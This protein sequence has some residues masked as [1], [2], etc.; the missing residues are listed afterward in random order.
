MT[1]V[2]KIDTAWHPL[3]TGCPPAWASEW[4]EDRYGVFIAFTLGE[5]TQRLRWIPPGRFWMGSPEEETQGLA[6][7]DWE[8]EW[9]EKEHPRHKVIITQG[10]WLF[11]T[12]CTQALWETVMGENQN[13][14]RF[15][16]Q[17][18]PVER[19][20][21][22]D[23]QEFVAR[24]NTRIPG[25]ELTLPTE[26]QWEHACRA[27][28]ETALYSGP[29]EILGQNN[30]PA[31][32][33]IAWYGGNSGVGFELEEGDDS[34]SWPEV[35]YPNPTSG[36]HPVGKKKPNPWGLYDMLGNVWEWCADG[37]REYGERREVD[38]QGP[39]DAGAARVFRGGSW[40]ADARSCR[41]AFRGR[42]A[43]DYRDRVLGFRCARAQES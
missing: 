26:A 1:N 25:L 8:R 4:G 33:P 14:S 2:R 37:W 11:D 31:L 12:P 43:P 16:S 9:F 27:R 18:R 39:M 36:T 34:S 20:S 21:W 5:V 10:F 32:D 23:A 17:D 42:S 30:A 40:G 22:D 24:I 29:I 35:Q 38:P 7:G 15:K 41:S 6:K 19:V 28:T 3:V 13:P